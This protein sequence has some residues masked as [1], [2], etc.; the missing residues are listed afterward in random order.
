M[1]L[2]HPPAAKGCE[3][4]A[5]IARLAGAIR[6][7]GL[8]CTLLDAN[9]EGQLFLLANPAPGKDT[10][11]IRA[12]K[13]LKDNLAA[14]RSRELYQ[15]PSRYRRAVADL[16]RV[17]EQTG[18]RH[19]LSLSLANYQEEG[20]SPLSST[21]LIRSAENPA[22][23]IFFPYFAAR[24]PALIEES[25]PTCIGISLNYLSQAATTFAMLGFLKKH[26]PGLPLVL[27]G[28]LVTSWLRN[29]SWNNP[30]AGL[31]DHC[32]AGPGEE[33]L[34]RL[35]STE[36]SRHAQTPS[37]S[38]LPLDGYLAPGLILPYAASSGCYWNN[39][40]FCPEKAEGNP[41][42]QIPPAT[43]LADIAILKEAH[44]PSLLHFLDNAISPAL[45]QALAAEPPGLDW[46]GFAR[47]T[48]LLADIHFCHSLRQSGCRMLKL[49]LESGDQDVL[50]AMNKGQDL[51]LIETVLQNLAAAGIATYIYLLFGTPSESLA[52]ARRT[53]DFVTRHHS[54]I[55]FL[56]LAVFNMPIGSPEAP[57]VARSAFYGGD[58]SLYTDFEHPK[59]WTRKEI[60][61]FLDQEFKRHPDIA[62]ILQ[63]DPPIFTSNHAAFFC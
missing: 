62:R 23:N 57:S 48:P 39:C 18:Q 3:P 45:M 6:G 8:P 22:A 51:A 16:N 17:L 53:L 60:R 12:G 19:H 42:Q 20:L 32:L 27:G 11:S 55:T 30:F 7:H 35:L 21:D 41:Y 36:F 13:N 15:N 10:W 43:V 34:I 9:L 46:Y 38:G 63:R 5:G 59:G 40:L 58:L 24:L 56:N 50:N 61:K 47:I 52:E 54:A 31:I 33:A 37:Y 26:Y 44:R 28:G 2:I 1:L 49:G 29:P 14:L 4:P 25:R